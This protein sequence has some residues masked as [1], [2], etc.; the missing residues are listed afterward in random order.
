MHILMYFA[1]V[2]SALIALLF[3]TDAT[4]EKGAQPIVTTQRVGLPETHLPNPTQILTST[5]AP[6][7]DM[8]S[9]LVLVA[10]PKVQPAPELLAV[11]PAARAARAEAPFQNSRV[12]D[13]Q[14]PA[15]FRQDRIS[16]RN[17]G[18]SGM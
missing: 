11:E 6:A 13:R 15:G 9:P 4:L 14:P 7:P 10:A 2:S 1:V 17:F 18:L 16:P 8:T 5:R 12:T 3:V